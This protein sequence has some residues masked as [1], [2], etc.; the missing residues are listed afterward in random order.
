MFGVLVKGPVRDDNVCVCVSVCVCLCL[1]LWKR[2]G[3]EE[4]F[5][6]C[7]VFMI[8]LYGICF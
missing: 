4:C 8:E 3:Q 5:L 2:G 1:C 6:I 7:I